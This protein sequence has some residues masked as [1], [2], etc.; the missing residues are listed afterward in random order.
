MANEHGAR[1]L[2]ATLA[3]GMKDIPRNASWLVGKAMPSGNGR[4]ARTGRR[5]ERP[6]A[7]STR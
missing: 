1:R 4:R 2:V 7:W 6:T 5:P 3:T